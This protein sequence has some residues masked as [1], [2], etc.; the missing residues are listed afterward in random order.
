MKKVMILIPVILIFL[1]VSVSSS[2]AMHMNAGASVWYAWWDPMWENAFTGD[3]LEITKNYDL[4]KADFDMDAEP[5]FGPMISLSF[6]ELYTLSFSFMY[7]EYNAESFSHYVE[8]SGT[9]FEEYSKIKSKKY[10]ADLMLSRKISNFFKVYSGLKIQRYDYDEERNVYEA[11]GNTK[12]N[13]VKYR[14]FGNGIGAGLGIGYTQHL[15]NNIY[16]LTNVSAIFMWN[17]LDR[18]TRE[19]QD[20]LFSP[21][22]DYNIDFLT[23]G[24]NTTASI[25]YYIAPASVT[26]A[27]GGRYQHLRYKQLN[28]KDERDLDGNTDN[29]YGVTFSALY[30]FE[31]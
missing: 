10:E 6:S 7:G 2:M 23:W 5:L 12:V 15:I 14:E 3:S 16:L 13:T 22:I 30:G 25:A 20:T 1:F 11:L 17:N 18:T 31:I 8:E 29:F 21:N 26:L 27:I 9:E 4:E 24:A 19:N 28:Q